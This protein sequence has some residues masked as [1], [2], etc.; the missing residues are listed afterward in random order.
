MKVVQ[1]YLHHTVVK[2]NHCMAA[3]AAEILLR[4]WYIHCIVAFSLT[5]SNKKGKF[6]PKIQRKLLT[7]G[8]LKHLHCQLAGG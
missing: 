2:E 3:I 4:T 7:D 6:S 5:F 8:S 1:Y